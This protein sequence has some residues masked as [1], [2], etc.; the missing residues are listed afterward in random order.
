MACNFLN[1]RRM[2]VM[3]RK[4]VD[5]SHHKFPTHL[6]PA[7]FVGLVVA[8]TA[9]VWDYNSKEVGNPTVL[10]LV[11]AGAMLSA[12]F[13]PKWWLLTAL[14]ISFS[15]PIA[16]LSLRNLGL[17]SGHSSQVWETLLMLPL[18]MSGGFIGCLLRLD[19]RD[20]RTVDYLKKRKK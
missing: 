15:I 9:G 16:H 5:V 10:F 11:A 20:P 14:L 1:S 18:S 19:S 4:L 13:V 3:G 7:L 6:A 17:P 8:T 2:L 12:I